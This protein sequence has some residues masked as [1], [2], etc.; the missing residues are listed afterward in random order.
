MLLLLALACV[1]EPAP[2]RIEELVVEGFV[3]FDDTVRL[4]SLVPPL[5][6]W[7]D[8]NGEGLTAG[9]GVDALGAADL[10]AA[11]VADVDVDGILGALGVARYAVDPARVAEAITSPDR[12]AIYAATTVFDV[13]DETG[14]RACFL[15][16][17]CPTYAFS[18]H[19]VTSV[20]LLGASER[21]LHTALRWVPDTEGV[22]AVR[23]LVPEPTTFEVTLMAVDQQYGFIVLEPM[24]DGGTR[25]SEAF[26]VDAQVLGLEVPEGYAVQQAVSR[27]QSSAGEI[28]TYFL[29]E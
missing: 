29:G 14:D 5:S 19:E 4:A 13:L 16:K 10:R 9:F 18:A 6:R 17:A 25:R 20:P 12:E 28:D 8:H 3:H 11:G 2:E 24:S 26:W 22:L 23:Q 15:A 1:A 27:M 21:V 7:V